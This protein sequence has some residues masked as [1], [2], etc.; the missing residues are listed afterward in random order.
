M[1][2]LWEHDANED[3][4]VDTGEGAGIEGDLDVDDE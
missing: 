2:P 1:Q 3:E 4:C